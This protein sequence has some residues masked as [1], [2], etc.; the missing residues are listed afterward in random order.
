MV[1]VA[2]G[3][4]GTMAVG[5]EET[6][7]FETQAPRSTASRPSQTQD[8]EAKRLFTSALYPKMGGCEF[9]PAFSW[10]FTD[11]GMG[12][13]LYNG[14]TKSQTEGEMYAR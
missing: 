6:C 3:V 1:G 14:V 5:G 8:K 2:L 4:G 10:R 7:A 9:H 12:Q 13:V 11:T